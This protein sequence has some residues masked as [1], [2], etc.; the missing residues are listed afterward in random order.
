MSLTIEDLRPEKMDG[1][2]PIL[3][4]PVSPGCFHP[5]RVKRQ[6]YLDIVRERVKVLLADD[7]QSTKRQERLL[8]PL[9]PTKWKEMQKSKEIRFFKRVPGGQ[10]LLQ[11]TS[12]EPFSNVRQAIENGYSSVICNGQVQGSMEDMMYG[13]TATSQEDLMTGLWYKHPPRDCVW[14]GSV[15]KSTP[16]DPFRSADFIW[17]FPRL[18]PYHVDICYLKATGIGKDQ[19]GKSYGYLVLH[20]IEIPHCRPFEARKIS[21]AKLYFTCLFRETKPGYLNVTIRGIFDL[22]KRRG[23]IAKKLVTAATKSFMVGL[24]DGVEIGLAKKLTFMARRNQDALRSTKQSECSICFKTKKK[25]LLGLDTHLSQC[26]VCGVTVCSNCIANSNQILF[27]GLDAPCS[28]HSCCLTCM[29]DARTLCGVRPE[30]PEFQVIAEYYLRRQS[31]S[32]STLSS[33]QFSSAQTYPLDTVTRYRRSGRHQSATKS[34]GSANMQTNSTAADSLDIDLFSE[35]LDGAYFCSS[36]EESTKSIVVQ[37]GP[38]PNM[39]DDPERS[40]LTVWKTRRQVDDGD[41]VPAGV[42]KRSEIEMFHR[43][44]VQLNIAAE[45]TYIQTQTTTRRLLEDDLD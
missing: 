27:L 15:E 29:R 14:L 28:K 4:F 21:R 43:T 12:E 3:K 41:F 19:D 44:L 20:S 39:S 42:R 38:S 1:T 7:Q 40:T 6:E 9:D 22:G 8:P 35:E 5:T 31:R 11:M 13:L 24:L 23:N 2:S 33:P 25:M 32:A 16:E 45:N 34:I 30:L 36:D 18:L 26:R 37:P 17:A 10:T